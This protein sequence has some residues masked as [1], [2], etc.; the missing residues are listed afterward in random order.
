MK[1]E[2][3]DLFQERQIIVYMILSDKFLREIAPILKPKY[4]KTS[5]AKIVSNWVLEYWSEFKS[6]P[7]KHIQDIYN[8][9]MPTIRDEDEAENIVNFI[10]RLEEDFKKSSE[11]KN[12]DY[13]I[14]ESIT[15]LK[16]RSIFL[17]KSNLELAIA[18]CEP[19]KGEQYISNY[20]R[21]EKGNSEGVSLFKDRAHVIS[22]FMDE[23][24]ELFSFPGV[25]GEVCG[26]FIRGDLVAFLGAA[27]KGKS[28]WLMSTGI[29]AAYFGHRVVFFSLEMPINQIVR[30]SWQAVAG[31]PRRDSIISIPRFVNLDAGDNQKQKY[32]IEI[33]EVERESVK[34]D[35]VGEQMASFRRQFRSGDMRI[36]S[37]PA[38][39]ATV[40]DIT[41]HLDNLYHFDGYVPDVVVIDYA[42]I[43]ASSSRFEYRHQIDEIWKKLRRLAQEKNIMV[44][45]ASQA[46]RKAFNKDASEDDIAEDIRK[47]AHVSK[48]IAI[49]QNKVDRKINSVRIEQLAERD[50]RRNY[51]Q[52]LVLQC[53]EIGRPFVDSRYEDE[54]E[55]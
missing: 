21:I 8:R 22:A 35:L 51:R 29:N 28:W 10:K 17:L 26:R 55:R 13:L 54:V 43:I 15:Y 18:A 6:C 52:V 31:K 38:Y 49:N 30:R 9:K 39:S 45:T 42:D 53:L 48:M 11:I 36:I 41:A 2:K 23:E 1:R 4:F 50:G 34:A 20:A 14:K 27:K 25:L 40:E 7:G 12:I 37:L 24:E 19:L 46:G 33:E 5:Y 16:L 3:I 32:G 47:I 44:A